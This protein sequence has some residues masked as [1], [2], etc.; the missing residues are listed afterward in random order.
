MEK[1]YNKL[2]RDKIPEKIINNNGKPYTRVLNDSEFK[3]ELEKKLYEEYKEMLEAS[4][5]D[6]VEELSDILEVIKALTLLEGITFEEL[7]RCANEKVKK[8]GAFKNKIYL[9]KVIEK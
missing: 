1:N 4:G 6:R 9:E 8:R 7:I 5:K 3:I 2:V